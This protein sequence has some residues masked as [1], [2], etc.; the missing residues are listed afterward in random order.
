MHYS[1]T[2]YYMLQYGTVLYLNVPY[3]LQ[4]TELISTKYFYMVLYNILQFY[5]I[6][7]GTFFIIQ[8]YIVL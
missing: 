4:I 8:Y 3:I 2:Q 5:T 1:T 7:L 6:L